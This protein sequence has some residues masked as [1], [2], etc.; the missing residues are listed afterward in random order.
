MSHKIE[1]ETIERPILIKPIEKKYASNEGF[2]PYEVTDIEIHFNENEENNQIQ[3]EKLCDLIIELSGVE[4]WEIA[5]KNEYQRLVSRT[6]SQRLGLR[7]DRDEG[8]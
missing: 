3:A 4:R 8:N 7:D 6:L 5:N 1:V 2:R